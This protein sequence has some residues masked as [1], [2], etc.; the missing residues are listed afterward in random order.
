MP[1]ASPIPAMHSE[2]LIA[3][4]AP[5]AN[6]VF[7]LGDDRTN[8]KKFSNHVIRLEHLKTLHKLNEIKPPLFSIFLWF[9]NFISNIIRTMLAIWRVRK[10]IDIVICFIGAYHTPILLLSKLLGKKII[11]FQPSNSDFVRNT[12]SPIR[13]VWEYTFLTVVRINEHLADLCLKESYR[14]IEPTK[15]KR[16]I[17]KV[18]I[19]KFFIDTN[20]FQETIPLNQRENIVGLIGRLNQWKGIIEFIQAALQYPDKNIR[21]IIIGDGP[22]RNK[23]VYYLKKKE[24]THIQFLGMV[25]HE[26]IPLYLNRFRLLVLPSSREGVSNIALEAM[27]CGTPVLATPVGGM[28]DVIQHQKTGFI[29]PDNSPKTIITAIESALSD[30]N[31][32]EIANNAKS[33]VQK[34]YTLSASTKV[35]GEVIKELT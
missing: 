1:Y 29:L 25:P 6:K 11:Y 28:P 2:K 24:A 13:K 19:V 21:F 5:S 7:V 23:I 15:T 14:E 3:G 31:L 20:I 18:R 33:F 34:H 9:W 27:A 12:R 17:K 35:W 10:D 8:V 32:D 4:V 30:P 26:Q 22:L 16:I